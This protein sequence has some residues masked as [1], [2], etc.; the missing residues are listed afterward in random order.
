MG[1]FNVKYL[2]Y[3]YLWYWI[4]VNK[5]FS[6]G[7]A[8]QKLQR[9]TATQNYLRRIYVLGGFVMCIV[10]YRKEVINDKLYLI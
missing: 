4:F 9:L 7:F 3:T 8:C 1:E 2:H 5:T 10:I 6:T